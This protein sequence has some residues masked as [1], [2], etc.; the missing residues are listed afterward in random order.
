MN[1][2]IWNFVE[3]YYPNYYSCDEILNNDDLLKLI[4]GQT[5][6]GADSVYNS[7]REELLE[8]FGVEP[9]DAE[10]ISVA[11]QKYDESLA[12]IYEKA[13]KGYMITIN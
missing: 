11:E 4:E 9:Y 13:I 12:R 7:I 3:K 8:K 10:V 6:S 1:T 2:D 5:D